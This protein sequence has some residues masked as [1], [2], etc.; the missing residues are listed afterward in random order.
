MDIKI[1][2]LDIELM[3]KALTQAKDAR[4]AILDIMDAA[5]ATPRDEVAENAPRLETIKIPEPKIRDI[6]GPG[7][8]M[9]RK[10]QQDSGAELDMADDG[11]LTIASWDK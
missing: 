11:T 4:F 3:K 8:K 7:G 5:L 2:G 6:I 9:I 10:I 1:M